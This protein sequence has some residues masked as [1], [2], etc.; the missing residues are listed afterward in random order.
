MHGPIGVA[1][2]LAV[3]MSL[4]PGD[5]G[6][7]VAGNS[8]RVPPSPDGTALVS[9]LLAA[10]H[11]ADAHAIAAMYETDGDFVSPT[12]DHAVGP[13]AVESFYTAAFENGYAGSGASATV[14]HTRSLAPTMLLIDGTWAI[15]PTSASKITEPEAGLF[16]VVL[17]RHQDHWR[18]V[19]LRE[20]TSSGS[21][22]ELRYP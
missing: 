18:I 20:Q 19:A 1:I 6:K 7:A 13:A 4:S 21:F 16:V 10:W 17:R 12:G 14:V 11:R 3:A 15:R 2:V 8:S 22:R 5:H 9:D